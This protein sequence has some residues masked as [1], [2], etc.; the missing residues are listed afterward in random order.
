MGETLIDTPTL[1]LLGGLALATLVLVVVLSRRSDPGLA[2]P[3]TGPT[4]GAA[5]R[6]ARATGSRRSAPNPRRVPPAAG[7][8]R[9]L[10]RLERV[11]R[12][13]SNPSGPPVVAL[14][15]VDLE[16]FEGEILGIIGPSGQGKS[17]LLNLLGGIDFPTRGRVSFRGR[18]LAREE[19]EPIRAH[20]SQ[21]VSFVFQDLNLV[22]HLD[23]RENAALPLICRGATRA[24][25]LAR[26]RGHL[27]A[28]GLAG[29][30]R[31]RPA[32]LSGG[33]Q[34]RVAIARAFTSE[35]NLILADEP[36]G[37][38]DPTT[39]DEVMSAF[40]RLS[41]AEGRTVVLVSHNT[42][43]AKR[44]CTRIV[45]CTTNGLQEVWRRGAEPHGRRSASE[46]H[47]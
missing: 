44:Y 11:T 9:A 45:R 23:A 17:T 25:A 15:D 27:E 10:A 21:H 19:G 16:I 33:Q 41:R 42:S 37:S 22:S 12:E 6:R 26:A 7:R 36:T 18:A 14:K 28:L 8:T 35:A 46:V 43:L 39:A 5:A 38:L 32:Q 2:R 47:A 3:Q 1:A 20:R 24:E 30:L 29:E 31:R 40:A 4:Q 13:Y 34:Q